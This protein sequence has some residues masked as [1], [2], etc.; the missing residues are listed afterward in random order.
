MR[1]QG[2]LVVSALLVLGLLMV[3]AAVMKGQ[4]TADDP[5]LVKGQ[6]SVQGQVP[7][8]GHGPVKV[9]DVG[10]SPRAQKPG[11]CPNI[12]IACFAPNTNQCRGD[13][14]CPGT[15]KCCYTGGSCGYMC[16]E[17]Q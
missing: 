1:F 6:D 5:A 16:L 8:K 4:D 14:S 3:E 12:S 13:F 7:A 10:K 2:V 15:E 9:Q 17:P 11:K